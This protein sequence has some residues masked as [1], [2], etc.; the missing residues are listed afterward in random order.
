MVKWQG[1][2]ESEN[3]WEPKENLVFVNDMVEKYE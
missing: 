1:F 2:P 3:T